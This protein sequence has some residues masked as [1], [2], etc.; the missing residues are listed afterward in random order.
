ML[1]FV[2][3]TAVANSAGMNFV[4]RPMDT[5]LDSQELGTLTMMVLNR[6]MEQVEWDDI[7]SIY[8]DGLVDDEDKSLIQRAVKALVAGG[9]EFGN[10]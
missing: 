6:F 1:K 7:V 4:K 2:E 8:L 10:G 9:I 3:A 5:S